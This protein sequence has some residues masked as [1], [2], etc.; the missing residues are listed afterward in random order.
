MPVTRASHF[1]YRDRSALGFA[2]YDLACW[3]PH[4]LRLEVR[5]DAPRS[6]GP[7][8]AQEIDRCEKPF[9]MHLVDDRRG[10]LSN[11]RS[12]D[13]TV[14]QKE[15]SKSYGSFTCGISSANIAPA[16]AIRRRASS[17]P[18]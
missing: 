18:D 2:G 4:R 3:L 16:K 9:G 11:V 12:R 8:F 14:G 1:E 6:A 13:R 15:T 10:I 5:F 7:I 17:S